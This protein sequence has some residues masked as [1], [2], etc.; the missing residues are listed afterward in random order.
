MANTHLID[1]K[2]LSDVASASTARTNLGLAIGSDI[3]AFD[4][5]LSALAGLTS[6]ADKLPYFTGSG[7]AS[8]TTFTS[9][10]RALV[11]DADATAQRTTLGLGT[12][13]TQSTG[14]SGSFTT[15]DSKTVTV[16]NGIITAIT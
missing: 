6:A 7:T 5:E 4:S 15:V 10:G 8:V 12:M 2:N 16:V 1:T 11:D 13:A 9:A 3:Q 14:A